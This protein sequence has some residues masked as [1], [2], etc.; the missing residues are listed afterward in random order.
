MDLYG[1]TLPTMDWNSSNMPLAWEKFQRH[2]ELI[3]K[4]P[5]K[6]KEEEEQV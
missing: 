6:G 4:G 1:I 3:F 5:L 2:V